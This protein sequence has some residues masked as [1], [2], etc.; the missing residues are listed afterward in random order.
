VLDAGLQRNPVN[1]I[2][3]QWMPKLSSPKRRAFFRGLSVRRT[4][5]RLPRESSP[6]HK[7]GASEVC[8]TGQAEAARVKLASWP[9][10]RLPGWIDR[11]NNPLSEQEEDQLR[12]AIR[13]SQPFGD[14]GWVESTARKYNLEST[15]RNRNEMT[16]SIEPH[17]R[18]PYAPPTDVTPPGASNVQAGIRTTV[19]V[20]I[21]CLAA[22]MFTTSWFF[23]PDWEIASVRIYNPFPPVG[24]VLFIAWIAFALI[25]GR[26]KT[27]LL[28]FALLLGC[29]LLLGFV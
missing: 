24:A 9:M 4:Q 13:R 3:F 14:S 28:V 16:H 7:T 20:A 25:R 27:V 15:L 10:P 29:I 17:S 5:V 1:L 23:R 18:G 12:R 26:W 6:L 22:G 19:E 11:V 8:I 21:L 2:A